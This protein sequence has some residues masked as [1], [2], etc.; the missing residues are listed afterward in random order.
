[1][2]R[3]SADRH[4]DR[5]AAE[6]CLRG[7]H[8]A[9]VRAG[10][11]LPAMDAG[12]RAAHGRVPAHRLGDAGVRGLSGE[13]QAD[14]WR[15]RDD[16]AGASGSWSH[17]TVGVDCPGGVPMRRGALGGAIEARRSGCAATPERWCDRD[18]RGARAVRDPARPCGPGGAALRRFGWHG[19]GLGDSGCAS[20][21]ACC[22]CLEGDSRSAPR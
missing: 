20:R 15:A 2:G 18:G 1:M 22:C 3:R 13:A 14:P 5:H 9:G 4:A 16:R 10:N 6:S 11:R 21:G 12:R 8:Q 19:A 17:A 7:V